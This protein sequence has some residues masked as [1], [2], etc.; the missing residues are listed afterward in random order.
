MAPRILA[1]AGSVREGSFNKKAVDIAAQGAEAAGAE[2]T[3]LD[4]ANY[5]LP[6]FNQ[7]L[8]KEKGLPPQARDLKALFQS[9]QG[10]LIA[11][12]E[13][14]S[15]LTA[16]LKN[17]IDWVSRSEGEEGPLVAYRDKVAV[18][19]A[20]SPGG[21]GGLRGLVHLRAILQNIG[22]IVLPKQLAVGA[23]HEALDSAK[24]QESLQGLG[25][26]LAEFLGS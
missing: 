2:V 12:P 20:A 18:L 3:R 10:L 24:T 4:L 21:L 6:I 22:V 5:P 16:L 25:R 23:S 19:M 15:S 7:D 14:N 13:Y 1:L 8:E 26:S 9:H 17:T 11:S